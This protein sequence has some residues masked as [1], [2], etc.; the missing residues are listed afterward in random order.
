[1]DDVVALG[2]RGQ[3]GS[4]LGA[5][6]RG[7]A[8]GPA[9]LIAAGAGLF[10]VVDE[11]Q[12]VL[13]TGRTVHDSLDLAADHGVVTNGVYTR[14]ARLVA[15]LGTGI[16]RM[17]DDPAEPILLGL[18]PGVDVYLLI[19][20][21]RLDL[22]GPVGE[23]FFGS[24]ALA[25]GGVGYPCSHDHRHNQRQHQNQ[26]DTPQRAASLYPQLP[27]DYFYSNNLPVIRR[28]Q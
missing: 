3:S 5:G 2:D 17:L 24:L 25:V 8:E 10:A 11:D 16:D 7:R 18:A 23:V 1:M 20:G 22:A 15:E 4:G 27:V 14:H 9:D 28:R 21:G 26:N 13:S 6:R 12:H 19:Q